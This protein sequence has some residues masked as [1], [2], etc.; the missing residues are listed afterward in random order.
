M[1]KISTLFQEKMG[2][3]FPDRDVFDDDF[4]VHQIDEEAVKV[5]QE[6]SGRYRCSQRIG[7]GLFFT[8]AE[9]DELKKRL[10]EMRLP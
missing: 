8:D 9:K 6:Y 4:S 2:V 3:L 10:R 5:T 7:K 1:S